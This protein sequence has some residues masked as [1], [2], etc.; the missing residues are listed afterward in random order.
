VRSFSNIPAQHL[1]G[2]AK[3]KNLG[4]L[5]D[6]YELDLECSRCKLNVP[7]NI[8]FLRANREMTCPRCASLMLLGISQ[9]RQ[10]MRHIEKQMRE[11]Y[12]QLHSVAAARQ[13]PPG[14]GGSEFRILD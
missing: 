6:A 7:R 3:F 13:N 14:A 5:I 8:G 1:A 11:L 10:E 2:G 12:R 9:I 4:Q